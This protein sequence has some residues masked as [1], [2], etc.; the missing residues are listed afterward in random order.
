VLKE[1]IYSFGPS[2]DHIIII[3][4]GQPHEAVPAATVHVFKKFT[5]PSPCIMIQLPHCKSNNAHSPSELW[6]YFDTS[7][8]TC[9]GPPSTGITPVFE[10]PLHTFRPT[11]F[12]S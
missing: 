10:T 6:L 9:F 5:F 12:A 2:I 3:A 4:S 8:V 7:T 11:G 1:P